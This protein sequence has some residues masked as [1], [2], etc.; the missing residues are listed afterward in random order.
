M[1]VKA[2]MDDT[3]T[4]EPPPLLP[5]TRPSRTPHGRPD[6][7]DSVQGRARFLEGVRAVA[8]GDGQARGRRGTFFMI[9]MAS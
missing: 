8:A 1:A 6:G 3:M 9:G 4:M 2:A 5:P 7:L